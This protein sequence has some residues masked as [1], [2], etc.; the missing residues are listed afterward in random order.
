VTRAA[1]SFWWSCYPILRLSNL[2]LRLQRCSRLERFCVSCVKISL[3][4][5]TRHAI[6][7]AVGLA[8][9]LPNIFFHQRYQ[10]S[11]GLTYLPFFPKSHHRAHNERLRLQFV[12]LRFWSLSTEMQSGVRCW[13]NNFGIS[14]AKSIWTCSL[15]CN[16][17]SV[18]YVQ[19][20]F[21]PKHVS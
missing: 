7:C 21:C 3:I 17:I 19:L 12:Y 11:E 14:F 1:S 6:N 20:R 10:L 4:L 9:E 16:I 15:K 18:V 13:T 5:K 2:K 8:P